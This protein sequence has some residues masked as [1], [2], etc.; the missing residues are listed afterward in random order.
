MNEEVKNLIIQTQIELEKV[1]EELLKTVLKASVDYSE[2]FEFFIKEIYLD[3]TN[4]I[5]QYL[6]MVK[7]DETKIQKKFKD[8]I[9]KKLLRCSIKAWEQ[10]VKVKKERIEKSM[11]FLVLSIFKQEFKDKIKEIGDLQKE[12]DNTKLNLSLEEKLDRLKRIVEI[13]SSLHTSEWVKNPLFI[14]SIL[15]VIIGVIS[16]AIAI[17]LY[18]A[19]RNYN[20][21]STAQNSTKII[22]PFLTPLFR[23]KS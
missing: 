10:L 4:I 8:E 14:I 15:G 22:I 1:G 21:I 11:K 20:I 19:A 18:F 9:K 12:L 17:I 2:L 7:S 13:Y 16:I 5:R 6:Q 23:K 3:L